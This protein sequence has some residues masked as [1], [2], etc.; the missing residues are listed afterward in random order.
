M[1]RLNVKKILMTL[2]V[3]IIVQNATIIATVTAPETGVPSE[4]GGAVPCSDLP[5][6][7][8]NID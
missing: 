7:D 3:I 2:A 4:D 1:K 6:L 5:P 8:E